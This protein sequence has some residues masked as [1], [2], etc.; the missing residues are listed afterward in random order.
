[1][2]RIRVIIHRIF[3][4]RRCFRSQKAFSTIVLVQ[5]GIAAAVITQM[6]GTVTAVHLNIGTFSAG[7]LHFTI[8]G[9]RSGRQAVDR[10]VIV[11]FHRDSA[12]I[13]GSGNIVRIVGMAVLSITALD[14]DF[15]AQL[16]IVGSATAIMLCP[17]G[18]EVQ[19][20]L[21]SR[22]TSNTGNHYIGRA[23]RIIL[24]FKGYLAVTAYGV[25]TAVSSHQVAVLVQ[26]IGQINALNGITTIF[27]QIQGF[28]IRA[29]TTASNVVIVKAGQL[30]CGIIGSIQCTST[31]A[32]LFII[33]NRTA[34]YIDIRCVNLAFNLFGNFIQ[35]VFCGRATGHIII[36]HPSLV[37]QTS[38]AGNI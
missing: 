25:F 34:R 27:R 5:C 17:I 8:S 19:P 7:Y 30:A 31:L 16:S 15:A 21:Q 33:G 23:S 28:T 11:Q 18:L 13:H 35:L 2:A 14:T 3:Q 24:H 26:Y 10:Q 4:T 36:R 32:C 22:I 1:M 29:D 38:N 37:R 6:N 9:I 12:I 20:L